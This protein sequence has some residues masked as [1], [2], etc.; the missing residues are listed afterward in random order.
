MLREAF[1]VGYGKTA[2]A[3]DKGPAAVRQIAHRAHQHVEARRP[4]AVVNPG[5][6]RA[7]VASFQRAIETGDLQGL[8]T[9]SPQT[10]S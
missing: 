2:A 9:C 4:R 8:P 1:G 10:P 5:D 7:A 6:A 3:V